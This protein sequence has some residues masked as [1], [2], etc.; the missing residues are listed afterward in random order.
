MQKTDNFKYQMVSIGTMNR[1]INLRLS[2]NLLASAER[3]AQKNGFSNLQEFIKETIREKI[4]EKTEFTKQEAELVKK[5]LKKIEK[6]D[7]WVTEK[8]LFK[9]LRKN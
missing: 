1:Q 2:D 4:Y 7:K 6:E 3:Y 5:A 8:E 9:M